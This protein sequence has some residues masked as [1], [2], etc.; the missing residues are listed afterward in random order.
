[1]GHHAEA[2]ALA[3]EELGL[4]RETG[5]AWG[6]A[7]ALQA[8]ALAAPD[9]AR[10][11][12]EE[13]IEL[14][15]QHGFLL[16]HARA[17][18][19]L[20]ALHRRTGRRGTGS[21]LLGEGLDR[22]VRCG[23]LALEERARSELAAAGLRPRRRTLSGAESLTAGERRV[24]QLAAE[25]LSNREIAQA[26]FVSLRTVETHLTHSYQKLGIESRADLPAALLDLAPTQ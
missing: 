24:A 8:L 20:G 15:E 13:A 22:S 2:R 7:I 3:E 25:G 16:E 4:A 26:L 5:S 17:L 12:L 23:A 21:N 6:T 18:V 10:E 19:L 9:I 14:S 11:P 1:M